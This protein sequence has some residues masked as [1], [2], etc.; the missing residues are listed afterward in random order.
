ML[1]AAR[2]DHLHSLSGAGLGRRGR[3]G[4]RVRAGAGRTRPHLGAPVSWW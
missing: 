1:A 2:A 3:G 4:Y